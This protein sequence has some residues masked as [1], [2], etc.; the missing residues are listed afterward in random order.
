MALHLPIN[1]VCNIKCLFCSAEGRSG[2]FDL[3]YLLDQI[4]R[5]KTGHVQI[6]GGDPMIKDPAELLQILLHCRKK[7]KIIEFQ[8]NGVMITRYNPKRLK[9]I[10]ELV[11]F[12]NINFSAH[13]PALDLVVTET[14]NAFDWRV[15]GVR[16]LVGMGA[17][18]RLN[19]IVH[20]ANYRHC[21]DFVRFAGREL[22]GISWIQFS[23]CKGMG[24]AKG[25]R[26][27]MPRFQDA[28]PFLNEA[29]RLCR[30]LGIEFDVDHIPVCFVMEFKERHADYRKMRQNSPG[31]H[32][33]EK[34][35]VAD[36]EGCVM[37]QVCP[38]PRRDYIEIYGELTGA[39]LVQ[40]VSSIEKAS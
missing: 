13:T 30:D 31:V 38:G 17:S 22:A 14:P 25:D 1:G 37:R 26:G 18:V 19:Y 40:A 2:T 12:F 39:P 29:F 16:H 23:Y 5:D 24:R 20:G 10:T 6:S 21:A 3:A 11:D 28:A 34:Q 27:V 8:T 36:C 7:R 15:K 32:L 4:S 35:Q 9:L 33:A